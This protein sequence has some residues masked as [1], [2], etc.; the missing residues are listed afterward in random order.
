MNRAVFPLILVALGTAS[1]GLG[2][3]EPLLTPSLAVDPYRQANPLRHI[4]QSCTEVPPGKQYTTPSGCT[5]DEI[6]SSQAAYPADLH[7]PRPFG[8]K[9]VSV[10]SLQGS[11]GAP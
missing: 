1:C 4:S 3:N 8:G 2:T 10:S 11:Q 6:F 7:R 5:L 9:G